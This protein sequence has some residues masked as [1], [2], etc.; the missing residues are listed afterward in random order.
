MGSVGYLTEDDGEFLLGGSFAVD[1]NTGDGPRFSLQSGLGWFNVDFFDETLNFWRIPV[2]FA[3]KGNPG[4]EPTKV[5]PWVMPRA[6][7][8]FA[9]GAGDSETET[10]F[11]A[12]GGISVTTANGLGFHSAIDALFAEGDA[13]WQLGLGFHYVFGKEGS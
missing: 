3:I 10:D 4:D 11:G 13:I 9:T 12:S 7:F 1:L 6:N 8:S 2:G 5:M